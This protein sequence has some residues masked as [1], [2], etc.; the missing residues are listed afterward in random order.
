MG[1]VITIDLNKLPAALRANEQG[2]RRAIARGIAIGAVRGR[3]I[4]VRATPVDQG[5]LKA[6]WKIGARALD[7]PP[8]SN[9]LGKLYNDA[10]H[11]GV[12]ELGARPHPVSPAGW[13]AI[14]EWVRRH[15]ELYTA[16]PMAV[17]M[18]RPRSGGRRGSPW[19]PFWGP[20]PQI[21]AITNAIVWKLRTKGQRPTYFIRRNLDRVQRAVLQEI[22]NELNRAAEEAR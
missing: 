17:R 6:S 7:V 2:V 8:G 1:A 9:L 11:A 12:V 4:L 20:D 15:P 18:R 5:Q 14:Y 19:K 3:A 21:M 10:P 16:P 22:A 13:I